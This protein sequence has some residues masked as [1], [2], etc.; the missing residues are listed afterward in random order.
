MVITFHELVFDDRLPQNASAETHVFLVDV[1]DV[2]AYASK[3]IDKLNDTSWIA[4][5][6]PVPRVSYET[7][8]MRTAARL[9]QIF[10]TA[11]GQIGSEFGEYMISMSAGDCL[12]GSLSHKI[13][14]I[15]ELWKEKVTG[16]PGFDFHTETHH[17]RISFGEAKYSSNQNPYTDAAE[18]VHRFIQEGKDRMDAVHLNHLAGATAVASLL[19]GSKGLAIAFSVHSEDHAAILNNALA[20]DLVQQLSCLSDEL[21]VIGVRA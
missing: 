21:Y 16:N 12:E 19:N 4:K 2:G 9:V 20:S 18:Q 8:A 15:S 1:N 17:D 6:A 3:L 10:Q 7:I 14:P 13:L 11:D 5:L